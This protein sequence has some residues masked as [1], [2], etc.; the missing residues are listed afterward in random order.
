MRIGIVNDM[1]LAREVLRRLVLSVPGYSIAWT[2]EDG[3]EAVRRAREDRPDAVLM[4]LV[5]PVM[6]GVEATR[7]IMSSTPC[8]IL[9]V[10]S[11]VTGN[12]PLVCE[13]MSHGGLDAVNIPVLGDDGRIH[14]GEELLARLA[15][16]EPRKPAQAG[17]AARAQPSPRIGTHRRCI[18]SICCCRRRW[19]FGSLDG[20]TRGAG[21]ADSRSSC[22]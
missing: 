9:V 8:P 20:R 15:R 12:F 17:A 4:D 6:G 16:V 5:M 2:A 19:P 11:S 18:G 1:S 7:R 13:A 3:A 10:T 22:F 14:G 21:R